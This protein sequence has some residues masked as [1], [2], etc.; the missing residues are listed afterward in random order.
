MRERLAL[1]FVRVGNCFIKLNFMK[2]HLKL[3]FLFLLTASVAGA[4]GIYNNG[5]KLVIGSGAKVVVNG[6]SGNFRNET[7]GSNGEVLLSGTLVLNGNLTN[8]AIATE[9][10]ANPAA[11][12]EVIFN[13]SAIQAI[14]GTCTATF[15]FDKLTLNNSNGLTMGRDV[16]INNLLNFQSG[17]KPQIPTP[18]QSDFQGP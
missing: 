10:F 18:S 3:S 4:Q 13:G 17:I 16:W 9:V 15:Q 6:S 12:S 14:G 5:G 2:I 7:S 1:A 8:N 11:G